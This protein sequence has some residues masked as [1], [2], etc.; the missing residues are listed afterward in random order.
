MAIPPTR[1]ARR[2]VRLRAREVL[3]AREHVGLGVCDDHATVRLRVLQS[4]PGQPART[5][6]AAC[7]RIPRLQPLAI[8]RQRQPFAPFKGLAV[9][10]AMEDHRQ[11]FADVLRHG[12]EHACRHA[13]RRT[14]R[15]DAIQV[16]PE[17]H[18]PVR[19]VAQ[20]ADQPRGAVGGSRTL[21][22]P[23]VPP[24]DLVE[25]PPPHR[26]T[27][28]IPRARCDG[29]TPALRQRRGLETEAEMPQRA[30]SVINLGAVAHRL[31]KP[32]RRHADP[33]ILRSDP[34]VA[35]IGL[36]LDRDRLGVRVDRVVNEI[37]QRPRHVVADV[38]QRHHQ[39]PR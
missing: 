23:R 10:K 21:E 29:Q 34:R 39:P 30:W 16:L 38:A 4:L 12:A 32:R 33:V 31:V 2:A 18:G 13:F 9:E 24:R 14:S 28:P 15:N 11:V 1:P 6:L 27:C 22:I 25:I 19:T 20:R 7:K 8:D 5:R 26:D 35:A 36:D 17:H 3:L 37:S